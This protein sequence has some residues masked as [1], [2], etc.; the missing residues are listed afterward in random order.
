M[1]VTRTGQLHAYACCVAQNTRIPV[2][3]FQLRK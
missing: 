3:D 1:I 2:L